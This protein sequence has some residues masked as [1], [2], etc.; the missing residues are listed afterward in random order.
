VVVAI[1][2]ADFG[3]VLMLALL[4]SAEGG[5]PLTTVALLIVVGLLCFLLASAAGRLARWDRLSGTL[6]RLRDTTAMIQVRGAALLL[7]VFIVV[8]EHIGLELMLG[9]FAAGALLGHVERGSHE[10]TQAERPSHPDFHMRLQAVGFGIFIPVFFVASGVQL[11]LRSLVAEG[12]TLAMVPVFFGGLLLARGLPALVYRKLAGPRLTLV[13]AFLQ[14]T[15]LPLLVAGARIG[16]ELG[17]MT[18]TTAAALI[19]AGMLSMLVFPS[20]ALVLLQKKSS[21]E[22]VSRTA[23]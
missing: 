5:G 10:R 13:A 8:V 18:E 19:S 22:P 3:M 15:S 23:P 12:S 11:N 14:A 2:I 16:V 7:V 9:A 20:A 21:P 4:F 6:A 1:S 17:R